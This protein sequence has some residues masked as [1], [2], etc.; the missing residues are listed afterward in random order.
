MACIPSKKINIHEA[1][2][3]DLKQIPGMKTK[4]AEK[5][6]EYRDQHGPVK[7]LAE[8][9]KVEGVGED[10]IEDLRDCLTIE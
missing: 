9:K 7:D 3:L 2:V 1:S 6:L 4:L 8:F 10:T 5:I